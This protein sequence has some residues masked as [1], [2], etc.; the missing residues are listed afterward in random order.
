MHG[1]TECRL[2]LVAAAQ[3]PP[4][5]CGETYTLRL[6]ALQ[7]SDELR[8]GAKSAKELGVEA[9]DR[10][11]GQ[12]GTVRKTQRDTVKLASSTGKSLLTCCGPLGRARG[13]IDTAI[14]VAVTKLEKRVPLGWGTKVDREATNRPVGAN[15]VRATRMRALDLHAGSA[16]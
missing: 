10:A 5:D 8:S 15:A 16:R 13:E 14:L 9:R 2:L 12:A 4:V 1:D 6:T 11:N 3:L 7:R